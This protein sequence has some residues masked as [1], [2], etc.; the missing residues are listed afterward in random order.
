MSQHDYVIDNQSGALFRTDL[1][2]ALAAIASVNS[3]ASTPATPYAYMQWADTTSGWLKQRNSSNTN[4]VKTFRLSNAAASRVP[5]QSKGAGY[6]VVDSDFGTMIRATAAI[7]LTMDAAATLEDGFHFT[8]RND[9]ASDCTLDPNSSETIN[10][11]ATMAIAP[12]ASV[13]VYC[14]GSAWYTMSG[15]AGQETGSIK[16]WPVTTA[17]TGWYLCDGSAISRTTYASLFALIGTTF[18]VGDNSTTFNVP[19]MRS[20][21]VIGYGAAASSETASGV[22]ADVDTTANTLVVASNTDKWLTGQQVTLTISSGTITGVTTGTYYIVRV[23]ATHV[24]L[25]S[26]LANAQAGTAI[27]FTAKSSPVWSIVHAHLVRGTLG[28]T[29][30]D[31]THA[32]NSSEL[33]AHTHTD[34]YMASVTAYFSG[35]TYQGYSIGY[36]STTVTGSAG[37]NVAMSV[38][39]PAIVLSWIIKT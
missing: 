11:A 6:N 4:W 5:V 14:N 21:G 28:Q 20:R 19:D 15:A 34:N 7:T 22:D 26:T 1:N 38:Q 27:D 18:G 35:G 10:G 12:A 9:S 30:G 36:A 29:V 39:N 24:S 16:P 31:E 3:G 32:M 17:P 2:G 25:S 13:D 8:F 33:L 37:G 23:D